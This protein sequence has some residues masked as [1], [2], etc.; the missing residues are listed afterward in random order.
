MFFTTLL[1]IAYIGLSF[2][3]AF[4]KEVVLPDGTPKYFVNYYVNS[5]FLYAKMLFALQTWIFALR[6]WLSGTL[7]QKSKQFFTFERIKAFGWA[8]GLA[9]L[10]IQ[11]V[12]LLM[13]LIIFLGY[14]EENGSQQDWFKFFFRVFNRLDF[15]ETI[16][17]SGLTTLSSLL[18]IYAI[19]IIYKTTKL[20]TVNNSN[21]NLNLRAMVL[22]STLL[23]V[24]SGFAVYYVFCLKKLLKGDKAQ[25]LEPIVDMIVQLLICY[26]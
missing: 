16:F 6:Y 5:L 10:I 2:S 12:D 17:Y 14:Y 7:I 21:I 24:Q 18:T 4:R 13:K 8:V 20:L 23:V 1:G 15:W 25:V 22:H 19:V 11:T 9:Y 26:I 3:K